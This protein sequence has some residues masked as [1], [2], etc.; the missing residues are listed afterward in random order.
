MQ[1]QAT[2][3]AGIYQVTTPY[4]YNHFLRVLSFLADAKISAARQLD[5]YCF[6][7]VSHSYIWKVLKKLQQ[8]KLIEEKKL[9]L[10]TA[11]CFSGYSLSKSGFQELK[12]QGQLEI[13]DIQIKSNTPLHDIILNDLRLF[14]SR[15]S[16]C[17]FFISENIIRSK[18]LEEEIP[19]LSIFRSRR[20][21]AAALLNI[22]GDR[23]WFAIEYERNQKSRSRYEQT[24]KNWYQDENLYCVLVVAENESVIQQMSS[25]ELKILPHITRK[26]LYLPLSNI[27][28]NDINVPFVN[29][30]KKSLPLK[31]SEILK[32]HH[33]ILNQNMSSILTKR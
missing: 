23:N 24:I 9:R 1:S 5:P 25:I 26:I 33:P 16:E 22:N 30:Q 28:K 15:L 6:F 27:Y 13:E 19:E 17:E 32:V 18:I 8:A 7:D 10:G 29:C 31:L 20:S 12:E 11:R 3:R 2:K 14:F 21:D 4:Q